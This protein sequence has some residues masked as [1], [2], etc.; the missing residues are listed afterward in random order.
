M[1]IS[2]NNL[3]VTYQSQGRTGEAA[4]LQ[5]E[6][7]EKCR[8]IL[9]AEHLD[10]LKSMNNLALTYQAQGRTREAVALEEKVL[11]NRRQK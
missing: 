7:L 5:E 6:V 1:L 3:A 11:E 8:Q 9:G 2:M 10:T 4:A